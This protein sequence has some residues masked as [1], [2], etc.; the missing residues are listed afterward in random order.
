LKGTE[1]YIAPEMHKPYKENKDEANYNP[2]K[3]D[4]YSLGIVL[5]QILN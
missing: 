5:L 1:D 3:T 2:K 4:A